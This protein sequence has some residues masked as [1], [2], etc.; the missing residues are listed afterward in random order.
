MIRLLTLIFSCLFICTSTAAPAEFP[1]KALNISSQTDWQSDLED[2][3]VI[4]VIDDG[5]IIG[6]P[7][8]DGL[9][10]GNDQEVPNNGVDD[11]QNGFIDD[12]HGWDVSD[13]DEITSPPRE[14]YSEFFHG[15]QS[16]SIIAQI[17]RR[18]LG[19]RD[20]YPIQ[21]M[22]IK[23][24]ADQSP[25]MLIDGGYKGITYAVNNGASIISNSWSG[26]IFASSAKTALNQAR[27]KGVFVVNTL[28]NFP[29][30]NLSHPASHPAVFGV[31]S[32]NQTGVISQKSNYGLEADIA[33]I[34]VNI[35]VITT[36]QAD[37]FIPSTGTSVALPIVSAT[38]ALMKLARPT[39]TQPEMNMCLKN[40]AKPIDALNSSIDGK[41]G[42][43]LIQIDDA[44]ECARNPSKY[45]EK[46]T[47]LTPE[48]TIGANINSNTHHTW[49]ILPAGEY[50]GISFS[51]F[52]TGDVGQSM[53]R[54]L[55]I[56][57]E[58]KNTILWQGQ[59]S[60]LPN[61]FDVSA[62]N[63]K[64]Q[65][66]PDPTK[67]FIFN[68]RYHAKL[69]DQEKRFCSDK[70]VINSSNEFSDGSGEI[71][72]AANSDCKW[73]LRSQANKS[74]V[75]E[76]TQLAIDPSDNVYLFSGEETYN[77]NLLATFTG[78]KLPPKIII[79]D[80]SALLWLVTD[81]HNQDQGFKAVVSWV[82]K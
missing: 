32:V 22:L 37:N 52:V 31:T 72:Y 26:G 30:K 9:I 57:D 12:V 56:N 4:A 20:N 60:T 79:N 5:F 70:Q 29:Q 23:A 68:S 13:E 65:L 62:A 35:P 3:I 69:V 47:H 82:P 42:A 46:E 55:S 15:T 11:D 61:S 49:K 45:L 6:H 77:R 71:E 25:S 44:I 63:V 16:A 36:K 58:S 53:I 81:S 66:E 21:L 1:F 48:G 17:I 19:E 54:F 24:V 7:I 50:D 51:S 27:N 64:I 67:Q 76:F 2:P 34:G 8:F 75:I 73:L 74:L 43:G 14:R 59:L 18:K 40:T 39:I 10:W 41:L 33:S 78:K 80:G 38:A 28:G